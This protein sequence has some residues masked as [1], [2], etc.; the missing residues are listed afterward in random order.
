M[1]PCQ[2]A[3]DL[4]GH[5]AGFS[6]RQRPARQSLLERLALVVGHDDVELAVV[7][8]DVVNGADVGIVESRGG[9]RF[10]QKAL[11]GGVVP[12]VLRWQK[13]DCYPPP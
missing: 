3:G 5:P 9:A 11:L 2:G 10:A 7:L 8:T 12:A 6:D 1:G 4:D 13:L